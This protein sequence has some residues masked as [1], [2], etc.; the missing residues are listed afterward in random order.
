MLTGL[1]L[2]RLLPWVSG[3]L[4]GLLRATELC[5]HLLD[6]AYLDW[7]NQA[8]LLTHLLMAIKNILP[9]IFTKEFRTID[10]VETFRRFEQMIREQDFNLATFAALVRLLEPC[11]LSASEQDLAKEI[12]RSTLDMLFRFGLANTFLGVS[13]YWPCEDCRIGEN[14][15]WRKTEWNEPPHPISP[16]MRTWTDLD[17]DIMNASHQLIHATFRLMTEVPGCLAH[18]ALPND[19]LNFA[20][21]KFATCLV[22]CR[23]H[24]QPSQTTTCVINLLRIVGNCCV[25]KC[26][27]DFMRMFEDAGLEI[28]DVLRYMAVWLSYRVDWMY[29]AEEICWFLANTVTSMNLSILQPKRWKITYDLFVSRCLLRSLTSDPSSSQAIRLLHNSLCFEQ[30]EV[31]SAW[32]SSLNCVDL[33]ISNRIGLWRLR[34]HRNL[35][36]EDNLY[37]L[38]LFWL[39][40][41]ITQIE[42]SCLLSHIQ[43]HC[44]YLSIFLH[45]PW[46]LGSDDVYSEDIP[47]NE[48]VDL[49][50]GTP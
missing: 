37:I 6:P 10:I 9:P 43:N 34:A 23:S 31:I 32:I 13:A 30:F 2:N 28:L 47:S 12:N 36:S 5:R 41:T 33:G 7:P 22:Q 21:L 1:Q 35:S 19:R 20:S 25:A 18:A 42:Q 11:L 15:W 3:S 14:V 38:R 39:I 48:V 4:L 26:H 27:V 29:C 49:L 8:C 40:R 17:E 46:I 16:C 24:T 45:L 44:K 50:L